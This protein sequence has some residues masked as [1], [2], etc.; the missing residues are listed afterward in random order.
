MEPVYWILIIVFI[1]VIIT[2]CISIYKRA[3]KNKEEY[4]INEEFSNTD[5][6]KIAY[7]NYEMDEEGI[8]NILDEINLS[9]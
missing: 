1:I 3:D 5:M 4:N 2:T 6:I 7:K 9:N 8:N